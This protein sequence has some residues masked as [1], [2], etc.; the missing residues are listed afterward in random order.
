MKTNVLGYPRIGA[1]REL[2]KVSEKYW[3]GT[4]TKTELLEMGKQL[5]LYNWKLMQ[6]AGVDL[7]PSNDFSFY[8]QVLDATLTYGC[9]PARYQ[10]IKEKESKLDLYF[11]MARGLQNNE[12]DVTA[13]EMT[14]W[15]DTNYHYLVPE[16]T[17]NQDF[18]LFSLKPVEEFKE[19]LAHNI[20]TK[21]V[22]LSPVTYLLLGKE[23]EEG[24]NKIDLLN[25]LLPVFFEL[26]TELVAAGATHVQ[27]DEP[28]LALNLTDTD[29]QAVTKLYTQLADKFPDLK[30]I[31]T[32]YF[33]CYGDNLETVLQL[34][35]YALHLDLVRC[36]LQLDD[37]LDAA[38]FKNDKILSLGL[39]DGRNIWKNNFEETLATV[40][41]V[42]E[43]IGEENVWLATSCSLLHT[44]YDLDLEQNEET[45][46]A[47]VKQWLA[48]AKQKVDELVTLKKL[49]TG[50]ASKD[51]AAKLLNNKRAHRAKK[52]SSV[53]HNAAVKARV[54]FLTENDSMRNAE[55]S[56]RQKI[57]KNQLKLPAYP[58]TTI[59]SFPQTKE[60]RSWR[61]KLKKKEL[62]L[63][64]YNELIKQEIEE[65]I[66]FQEKIGL[67]V[68]VHGE[69]ERNDMV[70]YFGEKLEGFAISS[71]GWVQ[72]YGSRAVKPPILFGD[73]SRPVP[74]TVNWSA[75]AQSLSSKVVKGM[76]TG[77]V[78][79]LQWSFVRN[80]QPRSETC[81]QIALAIRDEVVDLEN[82]GLQAIQV[83][84]PAIREGLPL[85]KEYRD[86]YLTWAVESFKIATSGVA[87]KTQIH[88]HMC[89]SEF[90]DII[91]H[92]TALDA[93]VITIETSRSKM[94]LLNVFV[95]YK[96]PNEIGPGV[97]DIHSP[98]VP[99]LQEIE[100]LL[101]KASKLLPTDN[102]WVNPD[103]GLKTRDWPETKAALENLVAAAKT[104]RSKLQT[105]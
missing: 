42:E 4:A 21:P 22:V 62:S 105:A 93:D 91:E 48:F 8:D 77:P 86:A 11:A 90:N 64:A 100:D 28:C 88:T 36:S 81:K 25:N 98:R 87:D 3:K 24:F 20:T 61:S 73:V 99:T 50:D 54:S 32:S 47:S 23:K 17:A 51:V 92:I 89:Y 12:F 15:F 58:T 52:E 83:D 7:I 85:R 65:T 31:L 66:R 102:I 96:Y 70:E 34:P 40:K 53:I 10:T 46:P 84:E 18:E 49:A 1:K 13:M 6:K 2:K 103:C 80:D 38:N 26:I 35:V 16:F 95:D 19:A 33:D 27:L 30:I 69:C 78:T 82:A 75:Y 104:M 76:L 39:I 60:V 57:Q 74:M 79:I 59:G 29:R 45:L 9:F 68:L 94:D 56:S 44:P 101:E 67:D 97:Y 72:S 5:K 37:V 63:D 55:F 43:K 41:K 14:K 71:F